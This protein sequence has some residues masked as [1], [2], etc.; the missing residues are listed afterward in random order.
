[1][2]CGKCGKGTLK[3]TTIRHEATV[4]GMRFVGEIPGHKCGSCGDTEFTLDDLIKFER[5]ATRHLATHGPVSG[6]TF[7]AMRKSIPLSAVALAEILHV[8]GETI[9][10]WET[11]ER[12]V[13]RAAWLVVRDLVL[14]PKARKAI[15]ELDAVPSA[16]PIAIAV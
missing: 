10:R 8:A 6:A 3:R 11:G 16:E 14:D 1:M 5:A 2:K 15:E 7:R 4:S 12:D 13:D 9:S